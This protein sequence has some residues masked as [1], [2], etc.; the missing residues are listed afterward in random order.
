MSIARI[1]ALVLLAPALMFSSPASAVGRRA[2]VPPAQP[3][4]I[5]K[6]P[7]DVPLNHWSYPL[8]ERLD[9]RGIIDLDLT[10]RPVSRADVT[11]AVAAARDSVSSA[12]GALTDRELWVLS[13]LEAEFVRGEVDS[14]AF[15]TEAGPASFGLGVTAFT[16]MRYGGEAFEQN[17][18]P[19]GAPGGIT[20]A[21][22][23]GIS[24]EDDAQLDVAA[25]I[26]YEVWGGVEELLG[27]YADA[28]VLMGG[29]ESARQVQLSSRVKTWRGL[30]F[31]S[32][33]AYVKLAR[34]HYSI[35][36]GRRGTAWGRSRWGGLMMSG[37]TPT[38]DQLNA[39]FRV[40]ALSFEAM[41][42]YL[43]YEELGTE[44]DMG[45]TDHAFLAAHR[46]VVRGGWGSVGIGEA[47]VY[48]STTPDPVYVNPLMPYYLSQ[49]NERENDNVLWLVD[50]VF[51]VRPGLIAYGEFLIDDLQYERSTEHPDKYGAT[52]GGAWY[53]AVRGLD[54]EL[55]AEY[56]NVRNWTYTHTQTEHRFA[57][58]G[59]PI[60]FDLGPDADRFR[61]EFVLHPAIKW[62]VAATYEHARKG[63]G[64]LTD[65]FVA[66]D[67]PEPTFPSGAV[68]TGNKFSAELG[69]QGLE[70]LSAG[71]GAAFESVTNVGN[72]LGQDDDKWEFWVGVE[73]R[74]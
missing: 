40:G 7:A 55:T 59:L 13:R 52:V 22:D 4:S 1:A 36:L 49:H 71:L 62:S 12:D 31:A 68:E 5:T 60:G 57:H 38:F 44:T 66:G 53:G 11:A 64:R 19:G 46:L 43:E 6:P 41:H 3:K 65:P 9:A 21:R 34:P 67:N 39:K 47:V 20:P 63:E 73:F 26:E 33:R 48:N 10:T 30:A 42:A 16:Q 70:G 69:Y 54:A 27:F 24:E 72:A 61:T 25:D 29:Q 8:L 17:L 51:N 18:W 2:E 15:S 58:D 45:E 23:V 32:E 56:T 35:V 28:V 37:T 14:P 50:G 74:I